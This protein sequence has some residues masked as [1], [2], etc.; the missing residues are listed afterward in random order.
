MTCEEFQARLTALSLGELEPAEAAAAR[1]H[2]AHCSECASGV[3]LDRQL[4]ALLRASVVPAPE[5]VRSSILA[6]L[7][8]EAARLPGR[9]A[10]DATEPRAAGSP[11]PPRRRHWVALG[12]AALTA[13]AVLALA[14]LLVPSPDAGS[15]LAAAWKSYHRQPVAAG[16]AP[17]EQV[18]H[19]LYAVLGPAAHTPDLS[20]V[21]LRAIGWDG[22]TLAGHLAVAAEYRDAAGRRFML[23]R[24][25]GEL[26]RMAS[27]PDGEDDQL[28]VYR[29]GRH[30]SAWWQTD[31][32][33]WCLIGT[34]DEPTLYRVAEHLARES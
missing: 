34:V 24:W 33:V 32:V 7:R 20:D 12:L 18:E 23:M 25:R 28:E 30:A 27:A 11:R 15:P 17:T 4:T 19:R 10:A 6:A 31:G 29:W 26:P 22:R 5:A 13:A 21:G 14:V 8:A 16:T 2:V 1:E 9:G 3:L